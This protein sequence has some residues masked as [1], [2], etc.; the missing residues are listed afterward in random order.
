MQDG[1]SECTHRHQQVDQ[2]CNYLGFLG[3]YGIVDDRAP[4]TE[5]ELVILYSKCSYPLECCKEIVIALV[6]HKRYSL[7][8][9]NKSLF[10]TLSPLPAHDDSMSKN[11]HVMSSGSQDDPSHPL[12][13]ESTFRTIITG[14]PCVRYIRNNDCLVLSC[15]SNRFRVTITARTRRHVKNTS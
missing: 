12:Q 4:I 13:W 7:E 11:N 1:R 10:D 2:T 15:L 3:R 6:H 5:F 14:P 9:L 8:A